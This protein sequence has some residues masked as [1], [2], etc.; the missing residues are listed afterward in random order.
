[1]S[2]AA[3]LGTTIAAV[4]MF[5]ACGG[6]PS[7][8]DRSFDELE[9][10]ATELRIAQE[11]LNG[12]ADGVSDLPSVTDGYIALLERMRKAGTI[13]KDDAREHLAEQ[14]SRVQD[15]CVSCAVAMDRAREEID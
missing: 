9:L 3:V 13:S 7:D 2:R 1:M 10:A 5:T 14:A 8:L 6:G 12:G 4:L 15:Y 11:V